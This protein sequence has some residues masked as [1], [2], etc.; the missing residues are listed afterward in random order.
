MNYGVKRLIEK[1]VVFYKYGDKYP[2]I[3]EGRPVVGIVPVNHPSDKP[4]QSVSNTS[5]IM[6]SLVVRVG[7]RGHFETENTLYYPVETGHDDVG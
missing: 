4:G 7:G 2:L 1:P 5:P 3:V 6:T